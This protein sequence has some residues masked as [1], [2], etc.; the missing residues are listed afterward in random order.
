MLRGGEEETEQ[1][2]E[3]YTKAYAD[4]EEDYE[5]ASASAETSQPLSEELAFFSKSRWDVLADCLQPPY[6]IHV[7]Y[8][9]ECSSFFAEAGKAWHSACEIPA[10]T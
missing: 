5:N 9:T 7:V 2:V 3:E 6:E 1:V 4:N 10:N 8:R